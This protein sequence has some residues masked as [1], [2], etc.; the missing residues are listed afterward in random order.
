[1][2]SGEGT[3]HSLAHQ[4]CLHALDEL[5]E[6]AELVQVRDVLDG[7]VVEEVV[8]E[9]SR[10]AQAQ[11]SLLNQPN[12][13][14]EQLCRC[15]IERREW[16][17]GMVNGAYSRLVGVVAQPGRVIGTQTEPL[18]RAQLDR[19]VRDRKAGLWSRGRLAA[20]GVAGSSQLALRS[21]HR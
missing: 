13:Q 6:L 17:V 9:R 3:E 7:L 10:D 18:E 15:R 2:H 16:P 11:A 20:A 14:L 4:G 1:M 21:W 12:A 8:R 19:G 5:R